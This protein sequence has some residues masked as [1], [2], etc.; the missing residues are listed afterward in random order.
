MT[1]DTIK[2]EVTP[3]ESYVLKRIVVKEESGKEIEVTNNGTFIMPEGKVTVTAIYNK[4]TNSE[5][6]SACYIVLGIILLI[7]IGI[8]IVNK[9]KTVKNN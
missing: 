4:I 2:V 8:L 1:A 6:V 5:T 7:S 3:K 9:Q